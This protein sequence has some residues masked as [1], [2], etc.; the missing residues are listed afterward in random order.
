MWVAMH[1]PSVVPAT[2]LRHVVGS[3]GMKAV[4]AVVEAVASGSSGVAVLSRS[5]GAS[6]PGDVVH[7]PFVG[8]QSFEPMITIGAP[9]CSGAIW[10]CGRTDNPATHVAQ[11]SRSAAA[12]AICAAAAASFLGPTLE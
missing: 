1:Q 11:A 4:W 12:L 10:T 6:A 5:R 2:M 3:A 8:S 9:P 7:G